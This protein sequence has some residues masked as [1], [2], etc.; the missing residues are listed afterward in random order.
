VSTRLLQVRARVVPAPEAPR[1][2]LFDAL[3]HEILSGSPFARERFA[4]LWSDTAALKA[5]AERKRR[6]LPGALARDLADLHRRLGAPAPAM[7]SLDRL[8]R[9]EAVA[10]VT[11]QQPA[12][13]GGP[14][15]SLHKIASAV[16][17]AAEV[18]RRTG[19]PC[20]PVFW[21]HGEDSDFA[22]IHSATVADSGLSLKDLALPPSLQ[23]EGGLVGNLPLAPL[24][25]LEA[26]ALA[27][28][29][30]LPGVGAV[31]GW[32]AGARQHAADLGE[33]FAALV[34]RMFA[35]SGLVVVDPRRAE[36]RA[37]ARPVIERY[38]ARADEL[39]AAARRA[40]DRL[41][42]H[43][44]RRALTDVALDSFAFEIDD[45]RRHKLSVG[46]ARA[47]FAAGKVLSP[48][49]ALRPAVQDGVL[50]TVAMTCGPGELAYLAQ[51]REVFAG[52]GV[53]PACPLPR[54][55]ATWLPP[56]AVQL[57][58]ASG[59]D[60]WTLVAS[61]DAVVRAH[62]EAQIPAAPLR[63]LEAAQAAA[64]NGLAAFAE[65][66]RAVDPSLPQMVESARG[67]VE[68]QYQRLH[69]GLQG[70]VRHR[71]ERQHPEWLRL[72]YYLLPGDK[73]QE[74]RLAS[75]EVAAHRG[76]A[77]GEE[78]AE[79]AAEHA[80]RLADGVHEHLLLEL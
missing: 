46:E 10:A 4:T 28:W 47:A 59:A 34:L 20:V 41:E 48:S 65:A 60:P 69:E 14:M 37:A 30:G 64:L 80:R 26:E 56:A 18:E 50:P 15:F 1:D 29:A 61:A 77:S 22:E 73:L 11:G 39:S 36:F 78:L 57:L 19:V 49:V 74:R 44:A 24:E 21:M 35:G 66:A 58:E 33:A 32:L 75:L 38:L 68:Y 42:A 62:A 79:L 70:K 45:G 17:A 76:A 9:G 2:R 72:R 6:P 12:P 7:A 55:A 53:D 31:A 8:A 63:A 16:G 27:L 23:R 43:G 5:L 25:G 40:G 67:K 71:L 54:F 3:T 13:L 51:L 52:V